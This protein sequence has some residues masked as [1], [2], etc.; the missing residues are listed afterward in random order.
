MAALSCVVL[1]E[2]LFEVGGVTDVVAIVGF[3]LQVVGVE[4]EGGCRME[5]DWVT[6]HPYLCDGEA[7]YALR[8]MRGTTLRS[9]RMIP[10]RA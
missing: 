6:G 1:G 4:D 7:H 8:A 9:A 2:A 10:C 5:I 3:L